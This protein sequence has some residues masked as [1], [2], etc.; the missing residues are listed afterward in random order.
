MA[1]DG[2]PEA[3][4]ATPA[5]VSISDITRTLQKRWL[6]IAIF[7]AAAGIAS[8]V[9][10]T[11]NREVIA[12][13]MLLD[14]TKYEIEFVSHTRAVAPHWHHMELGK[15]PEFLKRVGSRMQEDRVWGA[16]LTQD[17]LLT[18]FSEDDRG[19]RSGPVVIRAQQ[20]TAKAAVKALNLWADEFIRVAP[21]YRARK[22]LR[23]MR[24]EMATRE[25]EKLEMI[26]VSAGLSNLL[27]RTTGTSEESELYRNAI[28][29]KLVERDIERMVFD[30]QSAFRSEVIGY[31]TKIAGSQSFDEV[32]DEL[33]NVS[34]AANN[35]LF[36]VQVGRDEM[37][38]SPQCLNHPAQIPA[39]IVAMLITALILSST[40]VVFFDWYRQGMV[41]E[42]ES[43]K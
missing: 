35:A 5:E 29:A 27:S 32:A 23:E 25:K 39:K 22:I 3:S 30:F 36:S 18:I 19:G 14:E 43:R 31:L 41:K 34:D 8:A 37:L 26:A 38:S 11:K 4:Q 9:Y 6:F 24:T 16:P 7:T 1:N 21:V 12:A 28:R 15:S 33:K 2:I 20:P 10:Y 13:E 40:A 42:K 17:Q